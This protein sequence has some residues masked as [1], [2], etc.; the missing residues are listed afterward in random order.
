MSEPEYISKSAKIKAPDTFDLGEY[1]LTAEASGKEGSGYIRLVG[2]KGK[3]DVIFTRE[4]AAIFTQKYDT[5]LAKVQDEINIQQRDHLDPNRLYPELFVKEVYQD[6]KGVEAR[7][8]ALGGADKEVIYLREHDLNVEGTPILYFV[9]DKPNS[10]YYNFKDKGIPAHWC[11]I[12]TGAHNSVLSKARWDDTKG[13]ENLLE[14]MQEPEALLIALSLQDADAAA[15]LT[16]R[17]VAFDIKSTFSNLPKM[18][19]PEVKRLIEANGLQTT[20]GN[21]GYF[22]G[23][24]LSRSIKIN[25]AIIPFA[26]QIKI[27]Q[28]YISDI[29]LP[30]KH[31]FPDMAPSD[32]NKL[33]NQTEKQNIEKW[34]LKLTSLLPILKSGTWRVAT[35]PKKTNLASNTIVITNFPLEHWNSIVVAASEIV[36][37]RY[38]RGL[39]K[40]KF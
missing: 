17:R 35:F 34:V 40:V 37:K 10:R 1:D 12:L 9:K 22:H 8:N 23:N 36:D 15:R 24:I 31:D 16:S 26:L 32:F 25:D 27:P 28:R 3:E 39:R 13:I 5:L 6:P 30:S 2:K 14:S 19:I 33:L 4:M 38:E 11:L 21:P 18:Q 29:S 7:R 20:L